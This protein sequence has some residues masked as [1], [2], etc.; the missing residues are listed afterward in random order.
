M[1][2]I[3]HSLVVDYKAPIG[4]SSKAGIA[5]YFIMR[6]P[7]QHL[8]AAKSLSSRVDNINK[9]AAAIKKSY[10]KLSGVDVT[11]MS[12]DEVREIM[13]K[14]ELNEPELNS[15]NELGETKENE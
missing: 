12:F 11:G 3:I 4:S 8:E 1:H 13:Q 14:S 2:E 5:G 7:K 15:E 10:S 9:R 6:T